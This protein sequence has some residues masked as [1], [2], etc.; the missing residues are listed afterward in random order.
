MGV[1][2]GV[3]DHDECRGVDRVHCVNSATN[4]ATRLEDFKPLFP[5]EIHDLEFFLCIFIFKHM[6][7]YFVLIII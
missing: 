3:V 4:H 7:V 6:L 5:P 1:N 2:V